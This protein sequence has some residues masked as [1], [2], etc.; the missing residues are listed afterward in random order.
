MQQILTKKDIDQKIIR[1]GHQVL[2]NCFEE[3][4]IF[5]G[6][7]CGNGFKIAEELKKII[8]ISISIIWHKMNFST[9]KAIVYVLILP[10]LNVTLTMLH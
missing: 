9:K 3:P 1:L 7:I 4:E 5:I 10:Y 2:E 6:G 8:C